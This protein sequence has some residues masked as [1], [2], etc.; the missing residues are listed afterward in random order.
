MPK[1]FSGS[2]NRLTVIWFLVKVPVLSVQITVVEPSV[3]TAFIL[4]IIA[5]CRAIFR[6]PIARVVT[7][8]IGKPSG[9]IATN[10]EIA[11]KNWN[12]AASH[13][14]PPLT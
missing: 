3:S 7:K 11:T 2:I 8:I 5:L 12:F 9:T 10:I 1:V 14:S 13:N 4:R 6:I